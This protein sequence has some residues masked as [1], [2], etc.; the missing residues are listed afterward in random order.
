MTPPSKTICYLATIYF[1]SQTIFEI[2]EKSEKSGVT[3]EFRSYEILPFVSL[4]AS[5]CWLAQNDHGAHLVI[6]SIKGT[7]G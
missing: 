4:R 6:Q 3:E 5:Y 1:E 7:G 2:F